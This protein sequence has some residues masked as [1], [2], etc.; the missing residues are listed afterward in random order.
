MVS[1]KSIRLLFLPFA[2][3]YLL[4][5]ISG[6]RPTYTDE[7]IQQ[8]IVKI[9]KEE[10]KTEVKIKRIGK[11]LGIYLPVNGLFESNVDMKSQTTLEDALSAIRFT[12]DAA[13]KIDDVSTAISRVALST[14]ASID[15]YV[16]IAADIKGSGIKG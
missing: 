4:F 16:L 3:C 6:C 13:T 11:T 9:C 12:K 8:S 10:Y 15:F 14:N 5:A 1:K 2:I 7:N